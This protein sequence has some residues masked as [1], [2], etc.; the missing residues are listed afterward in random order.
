MNIM[1]SLY[2]IVFALLIFVIGAPVLWILLWLLN[3]FCFGRRMKMWHMIAVS[4]CFPLLVIGLLFADI[5]YDPYRT[6]NMDKRIAKMGLDGELPKYKITNYS[7]DWMEGDDIQDTYSLEFKDDDV[8]CLIPCLDSLCFAD[9][10]WSRDGDTYTFEEVFNDDE[11]KKT[12]T[13]NP[14][15]RLGQ[16]IILRW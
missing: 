10:R 2:F 7:S 6:S 1:M 5:Y 9:P 12:F 3:R 11:V 14:N 4:L 15:K 8:K 16:Y 13:I